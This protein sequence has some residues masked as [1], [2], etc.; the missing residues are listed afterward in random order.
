ME[1]FTGGGGGAKKLYCPGAMQYDN[2]ENLLKGHDAKT[3]QQ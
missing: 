2:C 1:I 3:E